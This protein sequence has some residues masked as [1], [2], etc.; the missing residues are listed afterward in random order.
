MKLNVAFFKILAERNY[1]C[2]GI[3]CADVGGVFDGGNKRYL[4]RPCSSGSTLGLK[5]A[6]IVTATF[7]AISLFF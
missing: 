7:G 4:S 2:L 1:E 5:I 6:F 3:R